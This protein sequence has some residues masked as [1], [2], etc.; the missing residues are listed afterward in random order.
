MVP[1]DDSNSKT[2]LYLLVGALLLAALGLILG[3]YSLSV[4]SS[5]RGE[6]A[7]LREHSGS[8]EELREQATKA[9]TDAERALGRVGTTREETQ[10][11]FQE[12]G[13]ELSS[14]R[15]S[16]NRLT[17]DLRNLTEKVGELEQRPARSTVATTPSHAPEA[18]N[19]T[20]PATTRPAPE[21]TEDLGPDR[22]YTIRQGDT[23]SRLSLLFGVTID[24]LIAAN[25]G[26]DPR[27]L[28]IGQRV[29]IPEP[30]N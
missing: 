1:S 21:R 23:F 18:G 14:F 5:L 27:R 24:E 17:I 9:V 30:G 10:R 20:A 8:L 19:V 26:V 2:G 22:A 28:R 11:A 29:I 25:P 12:V 7:D 16:L 3:I 13:N 15:T 6:L 4:A